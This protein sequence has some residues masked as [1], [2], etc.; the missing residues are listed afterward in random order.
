M[1]TTEKKRRIAEITTMHHALLLEQV[2][3]RLEVEMEENRPESYDARWSRAWLAG[4]MAEC[5][6]LVTLQYPEVAA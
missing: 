1:T 5:D 6:R 3:L 2:T 4:D